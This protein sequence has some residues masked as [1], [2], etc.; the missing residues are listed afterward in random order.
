MLKKLLVFV[1]NDDKKR[2]ISNFFSLSILQILSYLIPLITLPYLVRVLGV[3][4]FG[5][6][7]FA[8]ATISYFQIIVDYGFNY[9]ATREISIHRDNKEKIIEIFSSVLTIKF[10]LLL[11]SSLVVSVLILT[12]TRFNKDWVVYFATFGMVIGQM[13]FSI[14]FFQGI[15][16]MKYITYLNVIAK[17]FFTLAIFIFIKKPDDYYLVPVFNSLGI[18]VVGIWSL[19]IIRRKF[20]IF[21]RIQPFDRIL[22]YFKDGWFIF[23][24]NLSVSLYTLTTTVLLGLFTNNTIVGYYAVADKLISAFKAMISPISQALFPYIS[25]IAIYSKEKAFKIL[26]QLFFS[27]GSFMLMVALFLF[28]FANTIILK[29]FGNNALESVIILRILAVIPFIVALDTIF[30]SLNMLVFKRNKMYSNIIISAG[31]LNLLLAIILIPIYKHIGAA[32]SV[33]IVELYILFRLIRYTQKS[34]LKIFG[35]SK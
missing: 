3:G 11:F 30:G 2:L 9:T 1:N 22:F 7:S 31:L 32:V 26:R 17:T 33:L 35:G 23:V 24:S 25:R 19:F 15:E 5:L 28:I 12:I 4:N 27:I 10:F 8:T 21:F 14:W 29:L 18:I 16:S 20:G 34:D 13:L 6:I